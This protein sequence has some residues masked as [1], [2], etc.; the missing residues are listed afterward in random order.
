MQQQDWC[1]F[2]LYGPR[3]ATPR[4]RRTKTRRM[5]FRSKRFERDDVAELGYGNE[6]SMSLSGT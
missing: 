5:A 4:R 6:S 1:S 2:D 3:L